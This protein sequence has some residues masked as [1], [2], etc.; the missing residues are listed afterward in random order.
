MERLERTC[1][2][3]QVLKAQWMFMRYGLSQRDITEFIKG[4]VQMVWYL[5]QVE[6]ILHQ[7]SLAKGYLHLPLEQEGKGLDPSRY[8]N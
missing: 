2:D 1:R 3:R 5:L 8:I 4:G 6:A 7:S